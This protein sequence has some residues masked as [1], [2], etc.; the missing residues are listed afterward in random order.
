MWGN[1]VVKWN[2]QPKSYLVS[3]KIIRRYCTTPRHLCHVSGCSLFNCPCLLP[4]SR[5]FAAGGCEGRDVVSVQK[6]SFSPVLAG[7]TL[8]VGFGHLCLLSELLRLIVFM[9]RLFISSLEQIWAQQVGLNHIT[10]RDVLRH[11]YRFLSLGNL[12]VDLG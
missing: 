11:T 9:L 8:L 2:V 7:L 12:V 1:R 4:V 5:P 3:F 6:S 10:I